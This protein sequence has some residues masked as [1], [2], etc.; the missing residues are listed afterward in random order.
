MQLGKKAAWKTFGKEEGVKKPVKIRRG[1][2]K[3]RGIEEKTKETE[4][5]EKIW[6]RKN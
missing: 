5:R 3:R 2:I 1:K 4:I 6:Y